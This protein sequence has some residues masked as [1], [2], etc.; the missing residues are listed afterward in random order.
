VSNELLH[1]FPFGVLDLLCIETPA[2]RRLFPQRL[3]D[4]RPRALPFSTPAGGRPNGPDGA[5]TGQ[6][7]TRI[8]QTKG[9]VPTEPLRK[10]ESRSTRRIKPSSR[11]RRA[12][13]RPNPILPH[14]VRMRTLVSTPSVNGDATRQVGGVVS[15]VGNV[16]I[17]SGGQGRPPA[18]SGSQAV[19]AQ[20]RIHRRIHAAVIAQTTT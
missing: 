15:V 7:P 20:T 18:H 8:Y 19:R 5:A 6:R 12:V 3:I 10:S 1:G 4:A 2:K 16:F 17:S 13:V 9:C 11:P 14:G